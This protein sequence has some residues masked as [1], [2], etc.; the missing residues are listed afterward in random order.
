MPLRTLTARRFHQRDIDAESKDD[1]A[2]VSRGPLSS[3]LSLAFFPANILSANIFLRA[4]NLILQVANEEEE[5]EEEEE[6]VRNP[7]F[8]IRFYTYHC[9][10]LPKPS[11]ERPTLER[12]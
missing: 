4:R 7:F 9:R 8:S 6:E 1:A 11:G 12:S 10:L 2:P 5:E 3:T